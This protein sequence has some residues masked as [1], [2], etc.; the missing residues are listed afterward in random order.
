MS[1]VSDDMLQADIFEEC[2]EYLRQ[3]W[4]SDSDFEHV[5]D[6]LGPVATLVE[7]LDERD[8]ALE[9]YHEARRDV[10]TRLQE[11]EAEIADLERLA[12][13]SEA[14]LDAPIERLE[15]PIS[16]YNDAAEEAFRE[17]KRSASGR[18]VVRFLNQMEQYP[19]VEFTS[20]P[21][22]VVEYIESNPPGEEPIETVL[23]Y[24]KYSRSKLKHYVDEPNKLKH[25]I[26]GH[27]AYLETLDGGPLTVG[28]PP[29]TAEQLRY[30]CQELT[31]A[32]NRIDAGVVE[33]LRTVQALPR[34]TDYERLRRSAV[35]RQE[36]SAAE[37][38]QLQSRPIE[39]DLAELR[40]EHER[41]SE[42][43]EEYPER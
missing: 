35:V 29:P 2:D 14:D 13:L 17:F 40:E 19:L 7:R 12:D 24:A 30:R 42:V 38:Q 34:Q 41:L 22:D 1:D 15:E 36:L 25:A 4:F 8:G 16:Q 9:A 39:D 27:R 28:W 23:E 18:N 33:L 5:Y 10:R 20:P 26:E 31:A 3:K 6:L 43:L 32:V 37:R 21:P 11:C